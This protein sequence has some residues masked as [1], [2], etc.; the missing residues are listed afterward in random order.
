MTIKNVLSVFDS[1][2]LLLISL[3]CVFGCPSTKE[4]PVVVNV[5]KTGKLSV[6][7]IFE[8]GAWK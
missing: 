8:G 7:Q 4:I 1:R 5:R 2:Y 3:A 6:P